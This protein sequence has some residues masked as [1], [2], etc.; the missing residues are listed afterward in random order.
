[1]KQYNVNDMLEVTD[2]TPG[3][4]GIESLEGLGGEH[5][6]TTLNLTGKRLTRLTLPTG[7]HR[8]TAL[9]LSQ[10]RRVT[11]ITSSELRGRSLAR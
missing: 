7:L 10:M 5:N 4:V 9:E 2:L 6:L 3:P 11:R 1:M 8:L